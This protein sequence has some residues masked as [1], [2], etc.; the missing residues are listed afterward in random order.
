M[1]VL[2]LAILV[3]VTVVVTWAG[4]RLAGRA[5]NRRDFFEGGHAMPWWAVSASII[6]TVISSVTF[7]AVPAAVFK[8]GGD[9][10]YF[11]VLLGLMLGK[12]LTAVVFA[13]P[14]YAS[15]R[16]RSTYDYIGAR[17]HPAVGRFSIVLGIA[18]SVVTTSIKVLTTGLVLS[19]VTHWTLA[20]CVAAVVA[21]AILWS[22]LAGLKTVIWT[23]LILFGIFTTGAL[24]A[25]Y[26][27]SQHIDM[28]VSQAFA[29]LDDRAKLTLFDPSVDPHRT[30][31][32]WAGVIGGSLLSLA[33]ASSQG[34]LQRVRAC[35][36]AAEARKAY[37]FAAFF[38]LAPVCMLGVGLMLTLF[39]HAH[40][41]PADIVAELAV[42]PDR[43]FPYFI[44]N[45][46]P[47]GVSAIFIAAIF[48][49]GISTLDTSLTEIADV[50]MTH[51]Y[52]RMVTSPSDAHYLRASRS[53]LLLWGEVFGGVALYLQRFSG[54]GLLDLTFKLPNYLN[55]LLLGTI[56]LARCAVGGLASYLAGAIVAIA[57]VWWLSS[58]G[59]SFF[60]WCP[61]SALTMI[62]TVRVFDRR[63]PEWG[64]VVS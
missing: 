53:M 58:E 43:I 12:V 50:S 21:F 59:V 42:Q 35:R 55:G 32:L 64:G 10:G 14:Y 27:T 40:P 1:S 48:A 52:T 18:L 36:S 3:G 11:Q 16:I 41:L 60:W 7:I 37:I 63:R 54:Q 26:W 23:E 47:Q 46:I 2:D 62:A 28:T 25:I 6:A 4:H 44:V 8:P 5:K 15:T 29:I 31:T 57:T 13:R 49:A 30:Y 19:V 45:E 9:L 51:I 56:L 24:F 61:V 17:L 34:T 22:A 38:Y 39:Y 33:M 20:T